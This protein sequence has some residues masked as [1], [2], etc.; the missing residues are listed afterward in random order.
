MKLLCDLF[1]QFYEAWY[2]PDRSWSGYLSE[3]SSRILNYRSSLLCSGFSGFSLLHSHDI[4]S[5]HLFHS[6][7][8]ISIIQHYSKDLLHSHDII[9]RKCRV[10]LL[11][12]W[13]ESPTYSASYLNWYKFQPLSPLYSICPLTKLRGR[14]FCK[15]GGL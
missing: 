11:F 8:I 1:G 13:L 5:I 2:S 14:N 10:W 6:H 3:D 15:V 9:S 12:S 4:I 7:D